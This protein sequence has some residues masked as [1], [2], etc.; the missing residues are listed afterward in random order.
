METIN[1]L[2]VG[3]GGQGSLLASRVVGAYYTA[4]GYDV[5]V[6]EVHGMSQ[7]GGSVVT[8]VRAGATV[9]Q[10]VV[11]D[12]QADFV[13]AFEGLEALRWANQ[14]RPTGKLIYSDA[15]INPLPVNTGAMPYPEDIAG[16]FRA[17]GIDAKV[18]DAQ[19]L[20][21]QAGNI[22]ASNVVI[23]G[24]ASVLLGGDE[25]DWDAA[26]REAIPAKIIDVNLTAFTLGRKAMGM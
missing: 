26:L 23:L 21:E 7:R 19:S 4:R 5:K 20:A 25:A 1:I 18:I 10:P 8:Y 2:I 22:K 13:I 24:A 17:A 16:Q 6:S 3:V 14:L 9:A 11:P 12:G 15:R